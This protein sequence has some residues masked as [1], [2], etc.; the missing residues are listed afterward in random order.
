ML[1]QTQQDLLDFAAGGTQYDSVSGN[2]SIIPTEDLGPASNF[3]NLSLLQGISGNLRITQ[4]DGNQTVGD[5]LN[6]FD[7]L[8]NVQSLIIDDNPGIT[9]I[10]NFPFV[11]VGGDMLILNNPLL[12][13]AGGTVNLNAIDNVVGD[14]NLVNNAAL[15]TFQVLGLDTIGGT[16]N[17]ENND[18]LVDL[19]GFSSVKSVGGNIR[20]VENDILSSVGRLGGTTGDRL[21]VPI[22]EIRNNGDLQN[23]GTSSESFRITATE[24]LIIQNNADL[25]SLNPNLDVGTT[26]DQTIDSIRILDNA[27]LTSLSQLFSSGN[28]IV[29]DQFTL[30]GNPVLTG[31]LGNQPVQVIGSIDISDNLQLTDLPRFSS[32]ANP[33]TGLT[34]DLTIANNPALLVP[35][36]TGNTLNTLVNVI[37]DILIENNDGMTALPFFTSLETAGSITINNNDAITNLNDFQASALDVATTFVI[38]N[39]ASLGDCCEPTCKTTVNGAPFDGT[40]DAITVTGNTGDCATK[41][42]VVNSFASEPDKACLL[43]APVEFISF[44]GT[45]GGNAIVLDWSTATETEND[46]FQVERSNDGS[47]FT[48]IGRV[49]G[50]GD[51][52]EELSYTFYDDDYRSGVNYYRLR[53]VDYDGTE[54]FSKVIAIDAGQEALV[55]GMFPNPST[56]AEVNFRLSSDWDTDK[57]T[58]DVFSTAGALMLSITDQRNAIP[59]DRLSPGMYAVRF[60]DGTRSVTER[61]VIR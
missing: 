58:V 4:Y 48:A 30:S 50:A 11:R 52:Q 56:G 60:S 40:N 25:T 17:V 53:Q 54:D 35:A 24:A 27:S 39:N 15:S 55:L 42:N 61:L 13:T 59:V 14:F 33:T 20:I 36:N 57:T 37:G 47:S 34:G 32:L 26:A 22:L 28:P 46:Y 16:L 44:F 7:A 9:T 21:F 12:G 31:N 23:L 18:G 49:S 6:E 10:T 38:T 29:V 19:A 45:L 3:D 2:F 8:T 1:I 43:A 51:S 5:P 41:Q